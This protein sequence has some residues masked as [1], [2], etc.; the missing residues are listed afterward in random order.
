MPKRSFNDIFRLIASAKLIFKV[1]KL[2]ESL[3][4][5]L[6]YGEVLELD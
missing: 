3:A 2:E 4:S 1:S 5:K 6:D